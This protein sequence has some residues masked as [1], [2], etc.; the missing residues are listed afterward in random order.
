MSVISI[1]TKK[2]KVLGFW[3]IKSTIN[4]IEISDKPTL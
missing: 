1:I 4:F 2:T 3:A